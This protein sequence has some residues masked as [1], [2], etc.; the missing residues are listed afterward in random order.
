MHTGPEVYAQSPPVLEGLLPLEWS[1]AYAERCTQK[2]WSFALFV[3]VYGRASG[4]IWPGQ[5]LADIIE[6]DNLLPGLLECPPHCDS[7]VR[8]EGANPSRSRRCK[9]GTKPVEATVWG[10]C[11]PSVVSVQLETD[12]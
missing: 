5:G 10:S 11:Q 3:E 2:S 8:E 9:M 12:R 1:K 4:R 7:W 6:L